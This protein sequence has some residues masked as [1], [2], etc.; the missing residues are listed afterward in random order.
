MHYAQSLIF[1][2]SKGFLTKT[3]V[4]FCKEFK[5]AISNSLDIHDLVQRLTNILVNT[6]ITIVFFICCCLCYL[7]LSKEVP[8]HIMSK[9]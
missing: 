6:L 8:E 1:W 9:Q 4:E 2:K 3:G 5:G 7:C